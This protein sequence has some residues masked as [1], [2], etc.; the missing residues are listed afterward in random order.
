LQLFQRTGF[1]TFSDWFF[2]S[3]E[4]DTLRNY[5]RGFTLFATLLKDSGLGV[6]NIVD[7]NSAISALVR[8]LSKGFERDLRL[9]AVSLMK[10]AMGRVFKFLF[11]IDVGQVGIVSM[12]MRFYTLKKPLTKE[13]LRLQWSIEQLLRFLKGSAPF[14]KLAFN[15]LTRNSIALC[16]TF[17][18]L[19]FKEMERMDPFDSEPDLRKGEWKIRTRVKSHRCREYVWIFSSTERQLDSIAA[20]LEVRKRVVD[21]FC[22]K[23][24]GMFWH[25]EVDTRFFLS[26]IMKFGAQRL[27]CFR[28]RGSKREELTE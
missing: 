28:L 11:N 14:E 12:A 26:V 24:P 27:Q 25:K 9:S 15:E 10:T 1:G 4:N 7:A 5:R 20:L 16:M 17:T 19:R 22:G 8:T 3:L 6:D 23:I 13:P 18:V 2:K 21:R